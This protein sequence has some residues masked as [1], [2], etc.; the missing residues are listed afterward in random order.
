MREIPNTHVTMF[1]RQRFIS[2][3]VVGTSCASDPV[4]LENF[5]IVHIFSAPR[6][7]CIQIFGNAVITAKFG[8]TEIL[9]LAMSAGELALYGSALHAGCKMCIL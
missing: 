7:N 4:H 6:R 3:Q 2:Q 1:I 9:T 8:A 5:G